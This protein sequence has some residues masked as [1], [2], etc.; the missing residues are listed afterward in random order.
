MGAILKKMAIFIKEN[1]LRIANFQEFLK[2]G[3]GAILKEN[4]IFIEE[5]AL[6]PV[7]ILHVVLKF[8]HDKLKILKNGKS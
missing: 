2:I 8:N 4:T 7:E 5:N 6:R 3:L 1:A